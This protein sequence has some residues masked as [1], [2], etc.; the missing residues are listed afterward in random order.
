[1]SSSDVEF[2]EV[3][4]DSTIDF[5]EAPEAGILFTYWRSCSPG[6]ALPRW[7]DF[8][9]VKIPTVVPNLTLIQVDRNPLTYVTTMTGTT[10]VEEIGTDN[11][12]AHIHELSG[13]DAVAARFNNLLET[14]NGYFVSNAPVRWA[15]ND[16]K[17]HSALMLPLCD[18]AGTITHIVGWVGNFI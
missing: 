12:S 17:K 8:D 11:T 4:L 2:I 7:E 9:L 14:R 3:S 15:S 1:M 10:V 18:E 5:Q 6:G 13:G 16:F